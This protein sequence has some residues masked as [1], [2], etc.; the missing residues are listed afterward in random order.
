VH[1]R[2]PSATTRPAGSSVIV[3]A[4]LGEAPPQE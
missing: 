1:E 4:E 2:I 3:E